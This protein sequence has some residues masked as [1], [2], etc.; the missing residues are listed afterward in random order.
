VTKF[1]VTELAK[2]HAPWS[3][4]KVEA[5]E[6]CPAQFGHKFVS[7]TASAPA[8]S[9]TKVGLAAHEFLDHRVGGSDAATAKQAALEKHPLTSGE[10]ETLRLLS[11]NMEAF[12]RRFDSFCK[13]NGVT[14]VYRENA[15]AFDESYAKCD[16][17]NAYFRGKI[18]LG[19]VDRHGDL[20]LIDHKAG[21][22]K[23]LSEDRPK[24]DQLVSYAVLA[25][26]NLPHIGGVR[27]GINFLQAEVAEMQ[28]QWTDYVPADT[29][30]QAYAS[31]L[32]GR[33]NASA[34]NL[35]EPLE[36]RPARGWMKRVEPP[37]PQWPCGWCQ[38][39]DV[40]NAF[41]EKFSAPQE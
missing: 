41:K 17:K 21:K 38:Y 33:I 25:V 6:T 5:A 8:P 1:Q 20:W 3:F 15:W 35:V 39:T 28:L 10:L 29:I 34:S 9:D 14:E 27:G 36:A 22:V 4:S 16:W 2:K 13:S 30:K 19:A 37:R 26:V 24:K 7:R 12:L 40:C 32:F 31:W 23:D 11:D 18:D